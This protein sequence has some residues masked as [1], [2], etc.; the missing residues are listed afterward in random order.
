LDESPEHDE[1][2]DGLQF[3]VPSDVGDPSVFIG[4]PL[5]RAVTKVNRF[6]A[7]CIGLLPCNHMPVQ[8]WILSPRPTMHRQA[9]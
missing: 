1:L 5:P 9:A 6:G 3:G 7:I 2:R 8:N 4:E